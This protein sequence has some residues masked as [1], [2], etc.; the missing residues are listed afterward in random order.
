[1]N[2]NWGSCYLDHFTRFLGEFSDRS[3][4]EQDLHSPTVQ[5]L[6][7]DSAIEGCRSHASLGL[8]HYSSHLG[9]VAE[10]F[11]AADSAWDTV[12]S[13]LANALF[14]MVQSRMAIGRGVAI[15]GIH[16]VNADFAGRYNKGALY[17]T[18]VFG[19]PESFGRVACGAHSGRVYM[20]FFVSDREYRFFLDKGANEFEKVLRERDVDLFDLSRSS[21]I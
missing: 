3:V 11:C 5:I 16:S 1:M 15:A 20:S 4:F 19:F 21:L 6:Q 7:F 9:N 12:P 8:T 13:I 10:I 18:E 17:I 14:Y 2:V